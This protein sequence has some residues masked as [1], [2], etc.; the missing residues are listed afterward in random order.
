MK[1]NVPS[2]HVEESHNKGKWY[3]I[4]CIP[5]QDPLGT[6]AL[7]PYTNKHIAHAR[8]RELQQSV[9]HSN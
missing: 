1:T 9:S 2:Y 3:V 5:N 8:R 7:G 4:E 6:I